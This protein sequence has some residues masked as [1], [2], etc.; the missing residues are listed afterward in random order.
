M[1]ITFANVTITNIRD[2][3]RSFTERFVVDTGATDTLEPG[4][5]LRQNLH[6][7]RTSPHLQAQIGRAHV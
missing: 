6:Q 2:P 3:K 7:A 5:L 1:G 4:R